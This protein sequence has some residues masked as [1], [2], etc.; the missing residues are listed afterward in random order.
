[1]WAQTVFHGTWAVSLPLPLAELLKDAISGGFDLELFS[2]AAVAAGGG[3][4]SPWSF[5]AVLA[6]AAFSATTESAFF[7]T[8]GCSGASDRMVN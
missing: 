4:A 1:M 8:G 2:F 7:G 5:L 6:L 3:A